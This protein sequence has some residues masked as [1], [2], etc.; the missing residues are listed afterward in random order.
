MVILGASFDTPE[1]NSRF[2]EKYSFPVVIGPEGDMLRVYSEVQ[3]K[4][5]PEQVLKDL[6]S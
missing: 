4:T 1:K 6:G 2:K 5:H 3:A